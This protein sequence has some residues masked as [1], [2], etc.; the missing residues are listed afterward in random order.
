M[1]LT[2]PEGAGNGAQSAVLL[3][4]GAGLA[5]SAPDTTCLLKGN[6]TV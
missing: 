2:P 6:F 3:R 4:G 5:E 1:V